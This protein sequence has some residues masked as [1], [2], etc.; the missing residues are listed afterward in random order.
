VCRVKVPER[1]LVGDAPDHWVACWLFGDEG[2]DQSAKATGIAEGSAPAESFATAEIAEP[3]NVVAETATTEPEAPEHVVVGT[4]PEPEAP[5]H[6]VAGTE[7]EPEAPELE[8]A[9]P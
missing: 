7:P 6:V 8:G 3:E 4:E 2:T 1:T 9:E 5:E